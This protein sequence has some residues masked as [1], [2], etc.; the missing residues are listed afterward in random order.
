ML[1]LVD[2]LELK[3][4]HEAFKEY[5]ENGK[6][7]WNSLGDR[8]VRQQFNQIKCNNLLNIFSLVYC[9]P[10]VRNEIK[11]LY[12]DNILFPLH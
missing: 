8:Q 2:R 6:L 12:N 9:K 10:Q 5:E 7:S 3:I 1:S 4:E 11:L